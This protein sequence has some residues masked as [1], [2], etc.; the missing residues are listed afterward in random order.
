MRR[1]FALSLVVSTAAFAQATQVTPDLRDLGTA[2]SIAMG[3][4]FESLGYGSEAIGGNPAALG[5]Y[6]RY[7]I[8]ATGAWDIPNGYGFGSIGLADSTNE[9]QAGVS[10]TFAT[11]GGLQRRYAHVT[12]LAGSY[13]FGQIISLGVAVRHHAIVG[14]SNTNSVTMNAGVIVRPVPQFSFGFSGHNLIGVYNKDVSRYFVGSISAQ[15]FNQLSPA[16]DVRLDFNERIPRWA[17]HGG[18]EW[19]IANMVPIRAGYEYDGI[20]NPHHHYISFGAGWFYEGSGIDI[21]YRH[22]INGLN[23]REIVLTLKLQL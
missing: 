20:A 8:E 19:L 6:K 1:I 16:I 12:T 2:R 13:A 22:E 3:G 23:G 17:I 9:L 10:Y 5:L 21:A 11:Y 7:L 15:F 4:A 18:V 14:A